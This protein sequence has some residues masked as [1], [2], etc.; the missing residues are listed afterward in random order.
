M[1]FGVI[2]FLFQMAIAV[3]TVVVAG[4]LLISIR[5]SAGAGQSS[6]M[7]SMAMI[8]LVLLS[9]RGIYDASVFVQSE[10]TPPIPLADWLL[11]VTGIITLVMFSAYG[12]LV[13]HGVELEQSVKD[14][15]ASDT[16]T[17]AFNKGAFMTMAAPLVQTAQRYKHPLSALMV[18]ID[19]FTK[20]NDDFGR[21]AGDE[22]LRVFGGVVGAC[23]RKNDI[24]GRV[25]G[26]KFA[27]ILSHTDIKGA[28][29][30]AE[31]VCLAVQ[32]N[33]KLSFDKEPINL[34]A[35]VGVATLHDGNLDNLLNIAD[36]VMYSAKRNGRNQVATEDKLL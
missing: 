31:R 21:S 25:G 1:I 4:Q 24:L 29:V 26:E 16:L 14:L 8:A 10:G 36:G 2:F 6:S 13:V 12:K 5:H 33:V 20:L 17:G 35:S 19:H 30:V 22:A 18:D 27:I 11:T 34:T 15:S 7:L 3:A 28:T 9:A 32:R 23:L